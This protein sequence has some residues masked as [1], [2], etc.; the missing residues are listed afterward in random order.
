MVH[1]DTNRRYIR[2]Q[3]SPTVH[4]KTEH[5]FQVLSELI[6]S[7]SNFP[8]SISKWL[9]L[10][11]RKPKKKKTILDESKQSFVIYYKNPANLYA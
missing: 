4:I 10:S 3:F 7:K 11:N 8:F 2:L 5:K 9:F 6:C 1:P